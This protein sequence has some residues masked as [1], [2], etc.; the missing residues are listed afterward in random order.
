MIEITNK[1]YTS[2]RC[3]VYNEALTEIKKK[4]LEWYKT[5]GERKRLRQYSKKIPVEDKYNYSKT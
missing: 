3:V 4:K 2:V 5:K 1:F